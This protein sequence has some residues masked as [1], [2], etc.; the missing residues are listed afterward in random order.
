MLWVSRLVTESSLELRWEYIIISTS[1]ILTSL[2]KLLEL[3]TGSDHCDGF[4]GL[5]LRVSIPLLRAYE[6]ATLCRKAGRTVEEAYMGNI[7]LMQI[8]WIQVHCERDRIAST[9]VVLL[10]S[11]CF[12]QMHLL[13]DVH[14]RSSVRLK[15]RWPK[16]QLAV[17]TPCKG[18]L[19]LTC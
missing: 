19:N 12:A 15:I 1:A 18:L 16:E 8:S 9:L 6:Q 2:I 3:G 13:L 17:Y 14:P 4:S 5:E 7:N 11:I 10:S